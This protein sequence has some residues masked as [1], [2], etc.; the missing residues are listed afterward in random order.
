MPVHLS[1]CM[2]V[3]VCVC[4]CVCVCVAVVTSELYEAN[5]SKEGKPPAYYRQ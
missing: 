2:H 4:V 5:S 1:A 3:F